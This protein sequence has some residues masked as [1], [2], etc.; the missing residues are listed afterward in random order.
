MKSLEDLVIDGQ[1]VNNAKRHIVQKRIDSGHHPLYSLGYMAL[2]KQ[3]GTIGLNGFFEAIEIMGYSIL[4]KAGQEF[5]LRMLDKINTTN[6]KV[7]KKYGF[8]MNCEQVP[9][10][11]VAV[12]LVEKDKL[13]KY[14]DG[15]YDIYSNQFIPLINQA[16]L[17]DRI[18]LQGLFDSHFS[19]GAIAHLN[20]ES[21]IEDTSVIANLI[22]TAA[23]KGVVYFAVNY[24]LNECANGHMS[25]GRNMKTCYCGED[26]IM[27]YSRIV[28]F[29]TP[30]RTWNKTRREIDF[31]NRKFEAASTLDHLGDVVAEAV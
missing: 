14:N 3:F 8:P 25:V 23:S 12:K 10:E 19:G 6:E 2:S 31:P 29:L 16:D 15:R 17:L 26:I 11:S 24:V 20:V 18:E 13:L 7:Q 30:V 28:G 22:R 27:E 1:D 5:A 9:A 21:R 4:E